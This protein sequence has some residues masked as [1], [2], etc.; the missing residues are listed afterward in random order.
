ITCLLQTREHPTVVDF[1]DH[2]LEAALDGETHNMVERTGFCS[3][4]AIEA[5]QLPS[6][7]M[8]DLG[9]L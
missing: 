7:R 2:L 6:G 1:E 9:G 8:V 4:K 3:S 5:R